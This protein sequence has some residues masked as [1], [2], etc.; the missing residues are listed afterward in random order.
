M[1]EDND[2]ST[3]FFQQISVFNETS[4]VETQNTQH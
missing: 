1:Y 2:V 3:I 4:I